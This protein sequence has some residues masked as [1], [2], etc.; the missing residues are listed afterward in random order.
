MSDAALVT[1]ALGLPAAVATGWLLWLEFTSPRERAV[2]AWARMGRVVVR[3]S[4]SSE[5]A[6]AALAETHAAGERLKEAH[7]RADAR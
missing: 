7:D 5:Q 2:R 6:T 4:A 3:V 1:L